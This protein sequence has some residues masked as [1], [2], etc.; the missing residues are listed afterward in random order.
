MPGPYVPNQSRLF[1]RVARPVSRRTTRQGPN[2]TSVTLWFRQCPNSFATVVGFPQHDN[3][4]ASSRLPL[5]TLIYPVQP[6][7][8]GYGVSISMAQELGTLRP[9][10]VPAFCFFTLI[11]NRFPNWAGTHDDVPVS[12]GC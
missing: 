6:A 3:Q 8:T 4:F 12:D 10:L 7:S 9:T 1:Y 5:G 11:P 2:V